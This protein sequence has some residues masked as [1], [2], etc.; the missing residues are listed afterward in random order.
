[1]RKA[2]LSLM[3]FTAA[4]SAA[5]LPRLKNRPEVIVDGALKAKVLDNSR[6][7]PA[8]TPQGATYRMTRGAEYKEIK[9]F[10]PVDIWRQRAE[11]GTW[12]DREGNVMKLARAVSLVPEMD[13]FECTRE[14][15]EKKLAEME[16]AFTG[17]DEELSAWK[18]AWGVKG[19]GKFIKASDGV[20]Y[21]IEFRL[22]RAPRPSDLEKLLREFERSL[23][24]N[25][26]GTYGVKKT[27]KWWEMKD[28]KYRF[29]TDLTPGRGRQFIKDAL[30]Y[31]GALRKGFEFYVPPSRDIST[32]SVRLFSNIGEYREYR[33]STGAEDSWSC[34]LWD[35]SRDELLIV[36]EDQ[37]RAMATMRHESF[38]Q[39]LHYATGRGD[40]AMWFNEGHATF[41]E[42]VRYNSAKNFV[43]VLDTGSRSEWVARDPARYA[44]QIKAVL[45]MPREQFYSGEVN[46][47]YVTAWAVIYFLERGS[48]TSDEFKDY[49][50]IP[51]AYLKAM[52]E[53]LSADEATDRAWAAVES[54]DVEAD[55][56]KFWNSRRK[57]A[58]NAREKLIEAEK[59]RLRL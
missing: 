20:N 37:K 33:S 23:A 12:E 18:D 7:I 53:G 26:R 11:I 19:T 46:D 21:W 54:R 44:R 34:G 24:A 5:A 43:S 58:L 59:K 49:R 6:G 13:R 16:S 52:N 3:V 55:F 30:K 56:L 27:S 1:M 14:A 10:E 50:G 17:S 36:A 40:H 38:H 29:L 45:K 32:C 39:Y 9:I 15:L 22:K 8:A 35:P 28:G 51:A 57:A 42:N 48:Y 4:F 31:M 2:L 47:H 25:T 41:F